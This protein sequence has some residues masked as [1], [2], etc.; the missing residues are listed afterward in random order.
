V[1][2]KL[3]GQGTGAFHPNGFANAAGESNEKGR[4]GA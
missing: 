1:G 2:L 3:R 4:I